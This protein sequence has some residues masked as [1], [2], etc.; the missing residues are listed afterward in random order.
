[1]SDCVFCTLIA[2]PGQRSTVYEDERLVALLDITPLNPGHV[3]L[4]PRRHAAQLADV[5]EETGAHLFRIA[6]R[7][8][9]AIR[10]SGVR[11]EGINMF[12]ADGEAAFQ[13]V[14]H[15]HLHVFPRFR[16]DAFRIEADWREAP[17]TELERVAADVRAA[18]QELWAA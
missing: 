17:R 5:D 8:Q 4:V 15:F 13:D 16:G 18:Y 14:F 9:Q 7:T 6:M 12:V 11:C 2:D 10:R 3:L 1:M